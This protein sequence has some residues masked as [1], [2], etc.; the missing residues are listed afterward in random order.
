VRHKIIPEINSYM[1]YYKSH[2]IKHLSIIRVSLFIFLFHK[3][4]ITYTNLYLRHN[5]KVHRL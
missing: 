1:T 2:K 4:V 5:I 3:Q